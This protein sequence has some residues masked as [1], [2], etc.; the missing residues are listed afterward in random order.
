MGRS[1]TRYRKVSPRFWK[2]EKIVTL[3]RDEKLIALYLFTSPQSNRIGLFSFSPGEACEDLGIPIETFAEGWAKP[4][5]NV[6]K[7]LNL[8]FDE[9]ARVLF[10]PTWW[11]YNTPENPNVLKACLADLQEVPQT[12]LIKEFSENLE[13]LPETFHQTFREG[14]GKPSPKPSPNQE[15]EQEQNNRQVTKRPARTKGERK[16]TDPRV[17]EFADYWCPKFL[18]AFDE[19]YPWG[20]KDGSITK[21][22]LGTYPLD[23]LKELADRFF[24]TKDNFVLNEAGFTVGVFK[25]KIA[26]LISTNHKPKAEPRP[27]AGARSMNTTLAEAE[28]NVVASMISNPAVIPE[29]AQILTA[30]DFCS[31]DNGKI[32]QTTVDMLDGGEEITYITVADKV[33]GDVPLSFLVAISEGLALPAFIKPHAEIIKRESTRRFLI[34]TAKEAL[35]QWESG[36]DIHEAAGRL[37]DAIRKITDRPH[38]K[39]TRE[40]LQEFI[41]EVGIAEEGGAEDE[42][43][44]TGIDVLD[45]KAQILK[46]KYLVIPAGRPGMGKTAFALNISTHNAKAGRS[47]LFFTMESR[48]RT[49]INRILS[50]E[51]GINNARVQTRRKFTSNEADT[52]KRMAASMMDLPIT[53]RECR[54]WDKIKAEIRAEKRRDENLSLVVIDYCQLIRVHSRTERYL[55][56]GEISSD[57]K[58]MAMELDL[59]VLLLSQL[60]RDLEKRDD[61]RPMLADLRESGNLEQDGDVILL[62]HRPC[63]YDQ[64]QSPYA[65]EIN[66]AKNRDGATGNNPVR[67]DQSIVK[68]S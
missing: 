66:C 54:D 8:G 31:L 34:N 42:V 51:S 2:D 57:S 33:R 4:F 10:L 60:N 48:D 41:D 16:D 64:S 28:H 40:L 18:T 19:K 59:C 43:M 39:S 7:A 38:G 1:M 67:F 36:A 49:L 50:S 35:N 5:G 52:L 23:R 32:F 21:E 44:E 46:P 56:I 63:V 3:S 55:Q 6:R 13:H 15:Q 45:K 11:K 30:S 26:A 61:K 29:A 25:T 65:A 9:G 24:E 14:F 58:A 12:F 27:D 37:H 53:F 17:K 22:L 20:G 47:V 68:W 62:L